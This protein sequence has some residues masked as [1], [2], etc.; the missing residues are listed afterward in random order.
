MKK[1][2]SEMLIER[3]V[4]PGLKKYEKVRPRGIFMLFPSMWK[5]A[6]LMEQ[7]ED[8]SYDILM[9]QYQTAVFKH[10]LESKKQ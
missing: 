6:K 5:Q 8:K 1:T 9:L 2:F 3:G 7:L 4:R 10:Q